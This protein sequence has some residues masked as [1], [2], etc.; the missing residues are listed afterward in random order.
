MLASFGILDMQALNV[1]SGA[2]AAMPGLTEAAAPVSGFFLPGPPLGRLEHKRCS[3]QYRNEQDGALFRQ[4]C[5]HCS[6]P[7]WQVGLALKGELS[8]NR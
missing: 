1:S 8:P 3:E 4:T 5:L 2:P 7:H 6:P